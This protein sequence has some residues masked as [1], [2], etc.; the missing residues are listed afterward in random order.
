MG[1][2]IRDQ[3][4]NLGEFGDKPNKAKEINAWCYCWYHMCIL[5]RIARGTGEWQE[6]KMEKMVKIG[7][8]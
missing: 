2:Q 3:T 6:E 1:R 4:G 7:K 5:L 8:I